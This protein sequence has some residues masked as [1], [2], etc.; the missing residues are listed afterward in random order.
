MSD[1]GPSMAITESQLTSD[2]GPSMAIIESQI[3]VVTSDLGP[4]MA[5]T[6]SQLEVVMSDLRPRNVHLI[7]WSD[8]T[9]SLLCEVRDCIRLHSFSK[10]MMCDILLGLDHDES[11]LDSVRC[12]RGSG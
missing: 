4:S 3:E 6:E 12:G 8:F 9:L 2:L 11:D 10:P 5:I 1:L 7:T